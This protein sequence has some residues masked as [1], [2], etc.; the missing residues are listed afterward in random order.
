MLFDLGGGGGGG[1]DDVLVSLKLC[2]FGGVSV[3]DPSVLLVFLCFSAIVDVSSVV[4]SFS[5]VPT[6][7][8]GGSNVH[9]SELDDDAIVVDL[10]EVEGAFVEETY[11]TRM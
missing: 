6:E 3:L 9:C 4:S 2:P 5:V 7:D 10:T 11:C 8:T 1:G